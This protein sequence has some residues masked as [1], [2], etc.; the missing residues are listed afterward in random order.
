[1]T[2]LSKVTNQT[3]V[4]D[5]FAGTGTK[6]FNS[7]MWTVTHYPEVNPVQMMGFDVG[8]WKCLIILAAL[9]IGLRVL[10][11]IFLKVLVSKFQ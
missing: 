8:M 6:A 5:A 1:M 9:T 2:L 4:I 3:I 10:S 7:T 11:F